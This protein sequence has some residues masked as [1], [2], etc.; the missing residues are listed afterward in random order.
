M[1]KLTGHSRAITMAFLLEKERPPTALFPWRQFIPA[2]EPRGI[3]GVR[4]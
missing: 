4:Q 2:A 3:L 1:G